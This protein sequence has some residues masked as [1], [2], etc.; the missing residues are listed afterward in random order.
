MKQRSKEL[1]TDPE[2]QSLTPPL[3]SPED[4]G[5]IAVKNLSAYWI[6]ELTIK[7]KIGATTYTVTGSYEGTENFL[8]KLERIASKNISEELEVG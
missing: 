6:P 2:L 3:T 8:R 4:S 5:S 1:H 7:E